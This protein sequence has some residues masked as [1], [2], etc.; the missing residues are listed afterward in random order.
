MQ[1]ENQALIGALKVVSFCSAKQALEIRAVPS[2][3][4][5]CLSGDCE[6]QANH[7]RHFKWFCCGSV[8]REAFVLKAR[9]CTRCAVRGDIQ[10]WWKQKP[11]QQFFYQKIWGAFSFS[12]FG[13]DSLFKNSQ[14]IN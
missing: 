3:M 7:R 9:D 10:L 13:G 12:F 5:P 4:A 14:W 8:A 11:Q 1:E 6:H 2:R